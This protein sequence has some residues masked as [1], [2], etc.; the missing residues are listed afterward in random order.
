MFVTPDLCGRLFKNVR[1]SSR[2]CIGDVAVSINGLRKIIKL[3]YFLPFPDD[4]KILGDMKSPCDC[5]VLNMVTDSIRG[6]CT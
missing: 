1:V 5:S 6:S 2:T 3:S 4:V